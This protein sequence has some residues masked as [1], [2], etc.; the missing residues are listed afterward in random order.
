MAHAVTVA[1]IW[2]S[3]RLVLRLASAQLR[4]KYSGSALGALWALIQPAMVMAVFWFVFVFGL[5]VSSPTGEAPF[6]ALLLVGL[7]CWFWFADAVTGGAHAVTSSAYLVKKI[8]FPLE[9]LPLAPVAASFIVHAAM[10]VILIVGLAF[11]GDLDGWRLLTLP[12]YMLALATLAT[13]LAYWLSALN[14]F[15]RDVAQ[16]TAL[17]LQVWFWLT[18]IV[19]SFSAFPPEVADI[20]GW[21]P[22][23]FVVAGYRYALLNDVGAAPTI[24]QASTFT[25]LA[26]AILSS[27][28]AFYR[29]LRGDFADVL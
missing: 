3:R 16:T 19:W 26:V 9:V 20:L 22:M 8:A 7:S 14:A 2:A 5:K 6:V 25:I 11:A 23:T 28:I 12:L 21:N 27:G 1:E 24:A 13:G 18:P 17:V 15:H 29:R 4:D 10:L